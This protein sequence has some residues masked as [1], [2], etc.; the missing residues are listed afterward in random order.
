MSKVGRS[1]LIVVDVQ[2][3]FCE[4]GSLAVAGGNAVAERIAEQLEEAHGWNEV[5]FTKDWHMPDSTNGGHIALPP[6]EPDFVDTWPAHC[7]AGTDG[8]KL[9]PALEKWEDPRAG[10]VTFYKGQGVPAYSGFEAAKSKLALNSFLTE[11]EVTVLGVCGLATD[12]CV[13]ATVAD[14]FKNRYFPVI[15]DRYTAG[16]H[17]DVAQVRA[18]L[19]E[20][21]GQFR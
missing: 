2:R 15:L 5:I 8:A 7:I 12:Y 4:G 16:I 19:N 10:G 17:R 9:H 3:D 20:E 13:A 18:E 21:W 11:K 1:A 14:A 6:E